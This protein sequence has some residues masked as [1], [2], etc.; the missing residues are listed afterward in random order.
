LIIMMKEMMRDRVGMNRGIGIAAAII[1]LALISSLVVATQSAN[2]TRGNLN[3]TAGNNQAFN[4]PGGG[5]PV[6]APLVLVLHAPQYVEHAINHSLILPDYSLL[7]SSY[8]ILG[9]RI[10]GVPNLN[11]TPGQVPWAVTLY[12]WNG[13]FVNGT[14]T[15]DEVL[16]AKGIMVLE[17]G[18]PG[19]ANSTAFAQ[20]ALAQQPVC[21][22]KAGNTTCQT[23]SNTGSSYVLNQNGL[24]IVVNPHGSQLTWVDDRRDIGVAIIGG[25]H[26]V[27]EVLNMANTLTR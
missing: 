5:V 16:H 22:T 4:G 26:S 24:S 23:E 15:S 20:A 9:V 11:G 13:T 19:P 3:S 2:M 17:T 7:G 21:V 10:D 27:Q 6:S 12:L 8:R 25:S 1:G 18:L 14:T